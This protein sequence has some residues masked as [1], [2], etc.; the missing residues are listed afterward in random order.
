MRLNKEVGIESARRLRDECSLPPA[1]VGA[2][3]AF[4]LKVKT[5]K[6]N[7]IRHSTFSGKRSKSMNFEDQSRA[8]QW[9]VQI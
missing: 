6:L 5:A 2:E 4:A 7:S 8:M 1:C 9:V 3:P